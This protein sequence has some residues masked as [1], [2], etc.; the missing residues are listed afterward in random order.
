MA[1]TTRTTPTTPT[2]GT[3]AATSPGAQTAST[4]P[5]RQ[6]PQQAQSQQNQSQQRQQGQQQAQ[7]QRQQGQQQS[8]QQQNRQGEQRQA[9]RGEQGKEGQREHAVE[10]TGDAMA[11]AKKV[12]SELVGAARESALSLLDA[13]RNRA[14]DQIA[15][16]G[17][18]LRR[19]AESFEAKG[20]S[21]LTRYADQ[22]A[23]QICDFADTIR[24]RSWN[25]LASDIETF[26]RR[27]PIVY[28]ASAV[29]IGFIAGR[30]MLSSA[31][32]RA[33]AMRTGGYTGAGPTP[34]GTTGYAARTETHAAPTTGMRAGY[35]SP[36]NPASKE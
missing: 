7:A 20:G 13:Q 30:F 35:G 23:D 3:P 2:P 21:S 14:A 26:A 22:T 17:D 27:W 19:S 33:S 1:E 28:M 11:D 12:G 15:S 16:I 5:S 4:Q 9:E 6:Q 36:A 32:A 8:P 25:E 10:L 29:G 34:T 18:A 31:E 24:N